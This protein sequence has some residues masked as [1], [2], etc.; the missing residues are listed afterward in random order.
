MNFLKKKIKKIIPANLLNDYHKFTKKK[1]IKNL[2]GNNVCCPI[3]KTGFKKF[4][5]YGVPLREN[6][7]CPYCGSFERHRLL[8]KYMEEKT[9]IFNSEIP[10]KIL[11]FAPERFYYETF[12]RQKNT[13]YFPCDINPEKYDLPGKTKVMKVDITS[14]PFENNYFDVVL[15][16]HVLEH[17]PDDKK[18]MQE[19]YRVMKKGAWGIFQVPINYSQF[20]TYEDWSITDPKEREKAFGQSDHVRWYGLDYKQ[21]LESA[22]FVVVSDEYAKKFQKP[23]IIKFGILPNELIYYCQKL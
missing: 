19:L 10:K 20:L 17:I 2:L 18:A 21:R 16:N 3:C 9:D 1:K 6:A 4:E 14:I 5:P 15:C 7:K 12:S 13:H 23:E 8:W 22:G 11:H